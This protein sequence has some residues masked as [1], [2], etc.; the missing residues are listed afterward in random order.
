MLANTLTLSVDVNNDGTPQNQDYL[1][2][3]EFK[4]RSIYIGPDHAPE[5][6]NLLGFYRTFPKQ[7][8]NF[9]GTCKSSFKFTKEIPVPGVDSTTSLVVPVILEVSFS[10]PL[11][12]SEAVRK[13]LRQRA[14]AVLDDD[15]L[16]E[17]VTHVQ[18]V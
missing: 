13:E 7:S 5:L 4:D 8:G 10:T 2:R 11:G 15:S 1:R 17:N 9:R 16:M 14:V 3:E 6:K 12:T 18:M